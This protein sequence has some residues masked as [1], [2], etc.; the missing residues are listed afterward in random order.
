MQKFLLKIISIFQK[1]SFLFWILFF[2]VPLPSYARIQVVTSTTDLA[3]LAERIGGDLVEV[4]SLL[5]GS[6]DPHFVDALPSFVHRVARADVVCFVGLDLE[7]GWLPKVLSKSANSKVQ[8]GGQGYC[9]VS[10]GVPA[11]EVPKE[12]IDRSMGDVHAHGN[13]HYWLSPEH[14][15]KAA[16]NVKAAL[17]RVRPS[18]KSALEK[19]FKDLQKHLQNVE[20]ETR[21]IFAD[22][23]K[24][25][26]SEIGVLEYHKEFTYFFS[27]YGLNNKGSLE[28]IPGVPPS[29]G[30]LVEVANQVQGVNLILGGLHSPQRTLRRFSEISGTP[31]LQLPTSVQAETKWS[32]YSD[33]QKHLAKSIVS[34]LSGDKN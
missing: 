27:A 32:T 15:S 25:K 10:Q 31:Y 12:L 17:I 30:R 26:D 11:L 23:S 22:F 13:P 18:A 8:L 16:V 21:E 29:A 34:L 5:S 4:R 24:K 14:F 3:W 33:L 7:V 19:N 2:I 20:R 1:S 9:D 28:G 6:E